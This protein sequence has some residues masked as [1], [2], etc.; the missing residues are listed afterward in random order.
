MVQDRL[1]LREGRRAVRGRHRRRGRCARPRRSRDRAA[2]LIEVEYEPLPVVTDFERR[3]SRTR[4][5]CTRTGSNDRDENIVAD[6]NTLGYSTIVKGDAEAAMAGADVVVKG[7]YVSDPSQGVPIEPHAVIA[8]WQGDKVTIW[9]STQVPYIARAG[10]AHTL[11]MPEAN[12]RVVVPLLGGGFGAKCD[13]HFEAHVAA[14]AR[15]AGRPVKLVFS[16][17]EE[18]VAHRSSPRGHG[19][20]VRDGRDARRHARRAPRGSCSTRARTA[21]RAGSS[22]RWRRCTPAAR[23]RSSNVAV[24]AYL[25]YSTT[26][27]S[28][29]IRAPAAPQVCWALEQHMDELAA[30]GRDGPRRV[31]P[32]SLIAEGAEGPTRQIF[33]QSAC[34]RRSSA[35]SS[36]SATAATCP[37]TR[38]SA[39]RAAGGRASPRRRRVRPDEPGRH[40][41]D[42]DRRAGERHRRG[43][44]DAD[45][46]RRE[47]RHAARGLLDPVSGHRRRAVGHGFV[48]LAD[49]VQLRPRRARGRGTRSANSCSTPPPRAR[50]RQRRPRARRG[51]RAR[52]GL[53]RPVGDGRRARRSSHVHG[54]GSGEVPESPPAHG[55][56]VGRLG[57]ESF[58]A[59]QLFTHAAHVKVDRDDRRRPG[60]AGRG[61][62]RLRADPEQDGRR[63]PG[64]RR[65]RDGHRAGAV[66]GHACSTTR[67]ANATRTCSTTSSSPA[68]T[69]PRSTS[70]G[71]RSTPNAG[72]Q[73]SK[74]VGEPPCVP[75]AGAIA[76]AIATVI[77]RAACRDCR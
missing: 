76:N 10:V 52:E 24:E 23:T 68:P 16:R 43:H 50:G 70:T 18:F 53:A 55:G 74:G 25:N 3:W 22:R 38:P 17:E 32:R 58:L 9:S 69:R 56:C 45:V 1:P 37:T 31:P 19:D 36:S 63:R 21:A 75:T 46:R 5:S 57:N 67:A 72:P 14:L 4:T 26:Q 15:A 8:Q 65:R 13:F 60:A 28:G 66:G 54:K 39:S 49:H 77:G 41:H 27:P 35:R 71:S 7:R 47:A 2:A 51:S 34:R 61:R 59:P 48:R 62:A 40:G 20:G 42:R 6:R 12:V 73:G 30:R 11:Q 29:S 64:L 33:D 44:G